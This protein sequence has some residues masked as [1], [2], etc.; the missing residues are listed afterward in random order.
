MYFA[1]VNDKYEFRSTE[2]NAKLIVVKTDEKNVT[3]NCNTDKLEVMTEDNWFEI[4]KS[5]YQ[6]VIVDGASYLEV[7]DL[8]VIL[9][10]CSP[11][12]KSSPLA[13]GTIFS[14]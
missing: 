7:R 5:G 2:T 10:M 9:R 6:L 12:P 1:E 14:M 8:C 13:W 3:D 11:P 4:S